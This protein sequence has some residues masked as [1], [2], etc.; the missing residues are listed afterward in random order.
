MF[1]KEIS[2]PASIEEA[3][4]AAGSVNV[5][6]TTYCGWQVQRECKIIEVGR[7]DGTVQLL[8]YAEQDTGNGT[9]G[10]YSTLFTVSLQ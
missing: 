7:G 1:V 6:C 5:S 3:T 9:Y 10:L 8:L 2:A 4:I